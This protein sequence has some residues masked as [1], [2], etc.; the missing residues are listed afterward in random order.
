[1]HLC[2]LG[3]AVARSISNG[4]RS[5]VG[6]VSKD[7][8]R[9]PKQRQLLPDL[10]QLAKSCTQLMLLSTHQLAAAAL[11]CNCRWSLLVLS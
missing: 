11:S 10:F 7:T 5:L 1:M 9:C 8:R 4:Q 3:A 2:G 6:G